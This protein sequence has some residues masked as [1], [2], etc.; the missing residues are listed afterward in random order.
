MN[1][2]L[3]KLTESDLHKIVK[4]SVDKIVNEG[5]WNNALSAIGRGVQDYRANSRIDKMK[6]NQNNINQM[7]GMQS[8][9]QKDQ[10][11]LSNYAQNLKQSAEF[12]ANYATGMWNDGELSKKIQMHLKNVQY[13]ANM[14]AK[15][16]GNSYNKEDDLDNF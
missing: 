14:I 8:Q 4:E 5:F 16:S 15:Y 10:L 11:Q 3:I 2:K 9:S 7:G 12:I 6:A 1:N 13:Y